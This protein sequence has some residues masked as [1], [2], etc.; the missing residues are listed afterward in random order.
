[1]TPTRRQNSFSPCPSNSRA[2][3]SLVPC[4]TS[5]PALPRSVRPRS[6]AA[7]DTVKLSLGS[8]GQRC[9]R[10]FVTMLRHDYALLAGTQTA[11][12]VALSC[13]ESTRS[14]ASVWNMT[15]HRGGS[16]PRCFRPIR[17]PSAPLVG[18]RPG[19][20]QGPEE[21]SHIS[22]SIAVCPAGNVS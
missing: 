22:L 1:M 21:K 17:Q 20:K 18:E 10:D 13:A 6:T 11:S 7:M 8:A 4:G 12:T 15:D 19:R 3:N 9:Y 2:S 14:F 16:E 5:L